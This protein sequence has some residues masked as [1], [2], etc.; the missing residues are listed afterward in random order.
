M[1]VPIGQENETTK[2]HMIDDGPQQ[3]AYLLCALP[4]GRA[5]RQ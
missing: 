1:V 5:G 3:G 4:D 2:L